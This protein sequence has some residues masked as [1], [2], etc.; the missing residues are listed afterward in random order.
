MTTYESELE[1]IERDYRE[2][3]L[4]SVERREQIQLLEATIRMAPVEAAKLPYDAEIE[5]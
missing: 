2:G 4:T 1:S 5:W 3:A